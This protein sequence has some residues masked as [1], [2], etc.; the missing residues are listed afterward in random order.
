M[1]PT[2]PLP[3]KPGW[4]SVLTIFRC[5]GVMELNQEQE[6]VLIHLKHWAQN[7]DHAA[8]TAALLE[9]WESRL[10]QKNAF[11]LMAQDAG[12]CMEIRSGQMPELPEDLDDLGQLFGFKPTEEEAD[13]LIEQ[14]VD[15]A[16]MEVDIDE[17]VEDGFEPQ[18][19]W[20]FRAHA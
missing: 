3:L 14:L 10:R 4:P 19:D 20:W 13:R 6:L 2:G 15:A 16:T 9:C 5:G 1:T 17:V 7:A 12:I 18:E 8:L 11:V